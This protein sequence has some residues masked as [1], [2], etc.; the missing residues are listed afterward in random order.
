MI[1]EELRDWI[2]E[3]GLG[4]MEVRVVGKRDYLTAPIERIENRNI[5]GEPFIVIVPAQAFRG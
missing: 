5:N 4:Q 2:Q 3:N 1:G